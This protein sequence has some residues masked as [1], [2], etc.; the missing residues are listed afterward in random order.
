MIGW[1][2]APGALTLPCCETFPLSATY[3]S[4]SIYLQAQFAKYDVI[5]QKSSFYDMYA[6]KV[7]KK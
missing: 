3:N 5:T 1:V 2:L 4:Y 7:R 6:R